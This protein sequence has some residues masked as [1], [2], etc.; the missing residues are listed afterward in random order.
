[1]LVA[2][3][4]LLSVLSKMFFHFSC[5]SYPC[6]ILSQ[7]MLHYVICKTEWIYSPFYFLWS[8]HPS[9]LVSVLAISA[10]WAE[11][12]SSGAWFTDHLVKS[13]YPLSVP[14]GNPIIESREDIVREGN[15][16]E[17]T[18]TSMG[19]KPAAT[20][21]WMKG[22][23]EL[24]GGSSH[25]VYTQTNHVFTRFVF[26]LPGIPQSEFFPVHCHL[27]LYVLKRQTRINNL[28]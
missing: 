20:I 11:C 27:R 1:M 2:C 10:P 21:R 9:V 23:K 6:L 19:S 5:Y 15:E 17:I 16:T 24:Q 3:L 25:I 18:C 13:V 22:D 4:L 28:H 26:I 14:P 7:D 8:V 12:D